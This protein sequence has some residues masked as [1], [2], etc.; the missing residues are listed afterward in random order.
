SAGQALLEATRSALATLDEGIDAARAAARSSVG[1]L[2]VGFRFGAALEMTGPILAAMTRDHP[3]IEVDLRELDFRFPGRTYDN[4]TVDVAITRT[5][6]SRSDLKLVPLL[7]EP[8]VVA[9]GTGHPLSRN[10]SINVK[11]LSK[12]PIA[13]GD[14]T[15]EEWIEYWTLEKECG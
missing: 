5:P 1:V 12:M 3:G 15:D 6:T 7:Q 13:V 11:D 10:T 2:T 4:R 8:R 14:W 9:I